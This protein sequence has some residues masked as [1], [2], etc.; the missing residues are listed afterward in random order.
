MLSRNLTNYSVNTWLL[1]IAVNITV[2]CSAKDVRHSTANKEKDYQET[3]IMQQT[4]DSSKRQKSEQKLQVEIDTI[5][6]KISVIKKVIELEKKVSNESAATDEGKNFIL[7]HAQKGFKLKGEI[8][9]DLDIEATE[10]GSKSKSGIDLIY[11]YKYEGNANTTSPL[12]SSNDNRLKV[13][14][15][16]LYSRPVYKDASVKALTG[17]YAYMHES[18]LHADLMGN[19]FVNGARTREG[20]ESVDHEISIAAG[21]LH[22]KVGFT[23]LKAVNERMLKYDSNYKPFSNDY[24][25]NFISTGGGQFYELKLKSKKRFSDD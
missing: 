13:S 14:I 9:C 3:E 20:L 12:V 19:R 6:S 17:V 11:K 24:L 23:I 1:F 5:F 22:D 25:R 8:V 18:M 7:Q 4:T 10:E 16:M 21:S 15:A 2:S